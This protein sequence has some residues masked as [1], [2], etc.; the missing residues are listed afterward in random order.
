MSTT[1]LSETKAPLSFCGGESWVNAQMQ[2]T[3]QTTPQYR[4]SLAPC[5]RIRTLESG[6]RLLVE[7]VIR[8]I[9]VVESRILGIGMQNTA[10]GIR[11]PTNDWNLESKF[12][13][14]RIQNPVPGIQNPRRGIQNPRLSWISLHG[15]ISLLLTVLLVSK[16]P[17]FIRGQFYRHCLSGPLNV[18]RVCYCS[19]FKMELEKTTSQ[20]VFYDI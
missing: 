5:K 19:T 11:S 16:I 6:Q 13:Y 10:Q 18:K 1:L 2:S 9:W 8:E 4:H 12:P 7:S 20:V 14:Q 3:L 17:H 15:A